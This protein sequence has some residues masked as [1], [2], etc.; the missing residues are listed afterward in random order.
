MRSEH[1]ILKKVGGISETSK[2]T[3]RAI[4]LNH[5]GGSK[6]LDHEVADLVYIRSAQLGPQNETPTSLGGTS[7][8]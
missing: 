6:S 1:R 3:K 7:S 8:P 5:L 2:L 4:G